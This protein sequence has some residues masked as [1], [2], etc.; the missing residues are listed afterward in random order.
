V[1]R[2]A[3]AVEVL[4]L[5]IIRSIFA[6]DKDSLSDIVTFGLKAFCPLK[7]GKKEELKLR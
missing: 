1:G 6:E 4:F 2:A 7:K 3:I 5:E